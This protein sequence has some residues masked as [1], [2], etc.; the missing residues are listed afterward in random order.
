MALECERT[1][2]EVEV[3][4][5]GYVDSNYGPDPLDLVEWIVR[6]AGV[7]LEYLHSL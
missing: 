3:G 4:V 5:H 2:P 1:P 7:Q 6:E